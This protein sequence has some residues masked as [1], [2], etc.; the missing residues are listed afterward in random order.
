MVI[1]TLEGK[2]TARIGDW[3]VTGI[4]GEI[5]PVKPDIFLKTYELIKLEEA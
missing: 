5:Y 4:N 3:I 1:P 2:M